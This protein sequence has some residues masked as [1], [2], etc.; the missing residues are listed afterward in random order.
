MS[1]EP[2]PNFNSGRDIPSRPRVSV[3]PRY[4]VA[5]DTCTSTATGIVSIRWIAAPPGSTMIRTH[6]ALIFGP[7]SNG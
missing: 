3:T 1:P 6:I 2:P 4:S 7:R 5:R